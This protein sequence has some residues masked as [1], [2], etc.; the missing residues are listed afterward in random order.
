MLRL[1]TITSAATIVAELTTIPPIRV[2]AKLKP[3]ETC[4]EPG[5]CRKIQWGQW[6]LRQSPGSEQVSDGFSFALTRIG[7]IVVSSATIVAALVIVLS[8]S[9][10]FAAEPG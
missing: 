7:G 6:I 5:D 2:S 8:L 4:S 10:Y 3:S 9:I 1:S